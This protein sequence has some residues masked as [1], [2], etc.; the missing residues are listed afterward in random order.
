A[1]ITLYVIAG[2]TVTSSN[3]PT[4]TLRFEKNLPKRVD[5][6]SYIEACI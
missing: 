4:A 3:L 2:S 5:P 6:E 1:K